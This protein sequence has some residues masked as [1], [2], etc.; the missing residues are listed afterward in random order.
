[1]EPLSREEVSSTLESIAPDL[2]RIEMII[3]DI[4]SAATSFLTEGTTYLTQA[5]GKRLRPALAVLGANL[6]SGPNNNVDVTAAAI[7]MTHLATLYHDD[8]IDEADMR[9]GVPS[10]NEK[11]GNK[12]AI[13]AGD[14]LFARASWISAQVG[15]EVPEALADAIAQVVQGQVN[16]L[17]SAFDSAR[18]EEQYLTTIGGKTAALL[19]VAVRLG[20]SLA[21]CSQ[22]A[23][24]AMREFG[25]AFGYAFQIADDLLDLTA[26]EQELGK[27]PGT[28]L[29]DG[30]YTLP[31]IYAVEADPSVASHIGTPE[32]NVDAVRELTFHTGGFDRAMRK[33]ESYMEEALA[34]LEKVPACDARTTL[35]RVT[36]LVVDRVPVP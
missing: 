33:A 35:E 4:S 25:W 19:E 26:S 20:A 15:G 29:R 6:G 14:Y 30:V 32:V 17:S 9:R 5:G 1:M 13:L 27:P 18:S 3:Y 28:D 10:A 36:R 31:V 12:V 7:E 24:K 8:V 21:G 34:A 11:W 2:E 16:E 22:G 23:V